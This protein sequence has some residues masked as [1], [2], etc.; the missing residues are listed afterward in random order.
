MKFSSPDHT[1]VL[2]LFFSLILVKTQNLDERK[3]YNLQKTA[4]R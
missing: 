3:R 1:N 2:Q 4:K